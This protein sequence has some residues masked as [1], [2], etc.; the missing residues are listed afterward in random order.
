[1]SSESFLVRDSQRD[2]DFVLVGSSPKMKEVAR[3]IERLA[4]SDIPV[5]ISG[6]TGTGKE[7]VARLIHRNSS[8][9]QGPFI[10]INCS[11]IP[12]ELLVSEL[13]GYERGSFTGAFNSKPGLFEQAQGGT[14]FLD[15]I[16]EMPIHLQP[17]LLQVLQDRHFS[18]LGAQKEISVDVRLISATNRPL[19][20]L[21]EEKKFREDL[22]YRINVITIQIPPLRERKSDIA[23]LCEHLL[24]KHA[25]ASKNGKIKLSNSV[26][27]LLLHYDW[28]GNVRQLENT[29]LKVLATGNEGELLDD[30]PLVVTEESVDS[31]DILGEE[32]PILSMKEAAKL[33]ARQA[34]RDMILLALQ[35]TNW[36]RKRAAEL[37]KISYKAMLYKLKDAGLGKHSDAPNF[38]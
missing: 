29:I 17:K 26:M 4:T 30:F 35:R 14:I 25:A 22:F 1:M 13:F 10:K 20:R 15:E 24:Q 5:V 36:N 31:Q 28:P 19:D 6:E 2:E 11:A 37:L 21:L 38:G 34:E 27:D 9:K 8:R 12:D 23:E 18:R 16:S 33:A 32:F 3:M 7:V